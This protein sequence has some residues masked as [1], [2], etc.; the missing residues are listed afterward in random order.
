M[1]CRYAK[2]DNPIYWE[3]ADFYTLLKNRYINEGMSPT[4]A[5]RY[6]YDAVQLRFGIKYDRARAIVG[7]LSKEQKPKNYNQM[8]SG[9][10]IN[11][12]RIC[13]IIT[14]VNEE[15]RKERGNIKRK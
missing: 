6:A 12:I 2:L 15:Y 4:E 3:I 8:R 9:F 5:S 13:E 11:N 1:D 14:E 7:A 10:Y